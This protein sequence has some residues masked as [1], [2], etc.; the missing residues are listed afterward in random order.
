MITQVLAIGW[1]LKGLKLWADDRTAVIY[2]V[3]HKR[4]A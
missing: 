3:V 4:L 2:L 1:G